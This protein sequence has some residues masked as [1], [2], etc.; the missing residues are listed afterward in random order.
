M[1]T[2][3]KKRTKVKAGALA[4]ARKPSGRLNK[5]DFK[6]AQAAIKLYNK[7]ELLKELDR[8]AKGK[9]AMRKYLKGQGATT[10]QIKRQLNPY[11]KEAMKNLS[12]QTKG[13]GKLSGPAGK[14]MKKK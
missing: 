13:I 12:F 2:G 3:P 4:R 14:V 5:E 7:K 9:A 11:R 8:S 6:N 1:S 10:A